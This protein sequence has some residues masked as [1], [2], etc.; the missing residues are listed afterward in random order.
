[1]KQTLQQRPS[2]MMIAGKEA[3]GEMR[4]EMHAAMNPDRIKATGRVNRP[5]AITQD[6]ADDGNESR[7]T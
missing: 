6:V 1:M 5:S 3:H 2:P 4:R 7:N